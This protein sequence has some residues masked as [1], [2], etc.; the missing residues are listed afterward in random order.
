MLDVDK[1]STWNVLLLSLETEF[2]KNKH[3]QKNKQKK[4]ICYLIS[5]EPALTWDHVFSGL[6]GNIKQALHLITDKLCNVDQAIDFC[7][8]H[9]DSELWEDLI[10]HS[11]DKPSK[12]KLITCIMTGQQFSW[13]YWSCL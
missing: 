13:K 2:Y 1:Y 11:I 7:K 8:E 4:N 9:N 5:F 12:L 3:L 10:E 6:T